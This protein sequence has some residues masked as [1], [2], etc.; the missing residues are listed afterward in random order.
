MPTAAE[1][2]HRPFTPRRA[3]LVASVLGVAQF[4]VLSLIGVLVPGFV[5]GERVAMLLIAAAVAWV[6]WRFAAVRAV[7]DEEGLRVLNLMGRHRLDWAQIVAVRLGGGAPWASLDLDDGDTLPVMAIQ[8]ADGDH[9]RA[10]ARRLATLVA[11][12]SSTPRDD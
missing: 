7:P 8:Q 11:L 6:L 12:H 5:A 4:V 9:G 10:E 1:D 3:R 2:L